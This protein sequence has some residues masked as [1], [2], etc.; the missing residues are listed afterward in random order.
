MKLLMSTELWLNEILIGVQ[1]SHMEQKHLS[2]AV[3]NSDQGDEWMKGCEGY[4]TS[5]D[6]M[7]DLAWP[8]GLKTGY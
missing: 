1:I 7:V 5:D 8:A 3:M 2:N 4:S 6:A